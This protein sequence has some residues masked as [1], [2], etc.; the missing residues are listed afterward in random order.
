MFVEIEIRARAIANTIVVPRSALHD[1]KLYMVGAEKRLDIR[2]VKT[3]LFQGDIAVVSEGVEP[4]DQ[5]VVT[6]LIPAIAGML[7]RPQADEAV[8]ANLKAAAAGGIEAP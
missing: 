4:G 3:G 7:L 1:G 2:P 6:D 5:I 8:M